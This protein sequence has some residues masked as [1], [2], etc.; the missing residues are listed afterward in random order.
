MYGYDNLPKYKENSRN[1]P[2]WES[3]EQKL[4]LKPKTIMD[5]CLDET[6][7]PTNISSTILKVWRMDF[8][9][10]EHINHPSPQLGND[11]AKEIPPAEN[12]R[13]VN[14]YW[15]KIGIYI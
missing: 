4:E 10:M 8:T 14:E 1:L 6:K 2:I 15:E 12:Y 7:L 5:E 9:L 11:L 3:R 13:L